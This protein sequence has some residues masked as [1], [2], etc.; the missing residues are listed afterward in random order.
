M[1][2]RRTFLSQSLGA[3]AAAAMIRD[4]AATS[5]A[6]VRGPLD[7]PIGLQLYTVREQAAADLAGTLAAVAAIG[8]REV[9]LA[10]LHDRTA[11]EFAA[12]LEHAGLAAPAAHYSM[13]DLQSGLE[14]KLADLNVLGVEYLVCSFPGTPEPAR[15]VDRPGGP[16]AAIARGELTLDEWRWN[17]EQLNRIAAAAGE[18]GLQFAYHNH[19]MEFRSYDGTVAFDELLRLTDPDRVHLELDC[20]WVAQGGHEPAQLIGRLGERVRLLHI[21]DVKAASSSFAT[22]EVGNGRIDWRAVFA[23]ADPRHV[24]HYFV[25]QEHFDRPPLESVEVSFRYLR[26][27]KI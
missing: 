7:R 13:F 12:L 27:L 17:A 21:K 24:D 16:G 19:A 20:A 9:E 5:G 11:G 1:L 18:A 4:A 15:L 3:L 2:S 10:G 26:D 23:A 25:E 22:T 14:A 6:S 8:Y